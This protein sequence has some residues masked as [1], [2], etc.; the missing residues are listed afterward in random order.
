M[1]VTI[2]TVLFSGIAEKRVCLIK[3][4]CTVGV[5]EKYKSKAAKGRELGKKY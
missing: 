3:K 4:Y 5:K 2:A 1:P